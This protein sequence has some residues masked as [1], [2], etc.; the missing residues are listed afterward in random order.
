MNDLLDRL[1]ARGG[2]SLRPD[3]DGKLG[4]EMFDEYTG[5][6]SAGGVEARV[7][8]E[9]EDWIHLAAPAREP[10]EPT[11]A[12]RRNHALPGNLRFAQVH[13][14]MWLLADTQ[15]DGAAHLGAT[16]GE[17]KEGLA[18]ALGREVPAG[19]AVA[20]ETAKAQVEAAVARLNWD[21]D[22]L[23][24]RGEGWEFRVRT[25]GEVQAV[26]AVPGKRADLCFSAAILAVEPLNREVVAGAALQLNG[27]LRL[28][29][30]ALAGDELVAE[31][32]LHAGVL[33]PAWLAAAARA[34]AVAAR[35][36]RPLRLLAECPCVR[37]WYGRI[38]PPGGN[39]RN[40]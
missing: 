2:K 31:A 27:E 14:A 15:V 24:K 34:V 29:R 19:E 7:T 30:Y 21:E 38:F 9:Q 35:H 40:D 33:G 3:L 12:M 32:R 6:L 25:G 11:E 28:A 22:R 16:L 8:I 39:D 37:E 10:P 18:S 23:A 4:V 13:Q 20:A 26:A 5:R 1:L 36:A 17:F